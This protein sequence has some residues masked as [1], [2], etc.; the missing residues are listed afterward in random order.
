LPRRLLRQYLFGWLFRM[1]G[2]DFARQIVLVAV[3]AK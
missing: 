3:K 2:I 1:I